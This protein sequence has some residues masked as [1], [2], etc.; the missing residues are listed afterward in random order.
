[1]PHNHS[2]PRQRSI[3]SEYRIQPEVVKAKIRDLFQLGHNPQQ[4]LNYLQSEK[5]DN[6]TKKDLKNMHYHFYASE[7]GKKMFDYMVG[8]QEKNYIIHYTVNANNELD[9]FFL[10]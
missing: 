5:I 1:M 7:K 9:D 8:L 10:P 3:F 2:F 6:I 4:V